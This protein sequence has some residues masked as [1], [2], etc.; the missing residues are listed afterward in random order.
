[1]SSASKK[2]PPEK[3]PRDTIG[4]MLSYIVDNM[5]T[6]DDLRE[7][8]ES[9]RADMATKDDLRETETRLRADMNAGF[10]RIDKRLYDIERRL[11]VLEEQSRSHGGF[12][13]EI[14]AL[15]A[16]IAAIKKHVGLSR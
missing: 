14:D 13:K 16:E 6:K 10:D 7:L 11:D 2:R 8:E 9:I 15:R 3:K 4:D 12:A 1:M 5:A